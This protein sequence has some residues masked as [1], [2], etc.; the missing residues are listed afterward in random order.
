MATVAKPGFGAFDPARRQKA[1]AGQLRGSRRKRFAQAA[2]RAALL[3]EAYDRNVN[4]LVII[5]ER[6][7]EV[8][9]VVAAIAAKK[10]QDEKL[11]RENEKR[12]MEEA[13]KQRG[14]PAKPTQWGSGW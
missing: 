11:R 7:A 4:P 12:L 5:R 13:A 14:A 1:H 6:Q 10:H 3:V 9:R 2:R 8:D